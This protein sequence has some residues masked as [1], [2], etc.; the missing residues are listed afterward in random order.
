MRVGQK[1]LAHELGIKQ[2]AYS[3]IENGHTEITL[4]QFI[5]LC[6]RLKMNAAQYLIPQANNSPLQKS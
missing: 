3:R 1:T 5:F 6:S 4:K 2:A